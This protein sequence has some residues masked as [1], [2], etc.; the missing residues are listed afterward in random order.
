MADEKNQAALVKQRGKIKGCC[1]RIKTYVDAVESATPVVRAQIE[2]KLDMYWSEYDTVQSSLEAIDETEVN[3]RAAFEEAFYSL[4]GKIREMLNLGAARSAAAPGPSTSVRSTTEP[5]IHIQLPR[6]NLPKFSGKYEEWFPFFDTF[7]SII[8]SN[9][10]LNATQKFQ[11][12][13]TSLVG[14]ATNVIHSLEITEA[15]YEIA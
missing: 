9:E 13:R 6:L 1:T 4:C 10:S 8:H 3:D 5:S 11:Y 7:N 2:D 15:N 14:D 12:L